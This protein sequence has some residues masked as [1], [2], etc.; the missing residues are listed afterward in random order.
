MNF[1]V[2]KVK[3]ERLEL[4]EIIAELI[5]ELK[6]DENFAALFVRLLIYKKLDKYNF[7]DKHYNKIYFCGECCKFTGNHIS[8]NTECPCM[9]CG[10]CCKCYCDRE[11][12]DGCDCSLYHRDNRCQTCFCSKTLL[13]RKYSLDIGVDNLPL[14]KKVMLFI[15]K[16]QDIF[17]C[18]YKMN[19]FVEEVVEGVMELS[20][21]TRKSHLAMCMNCNA[22]FED[23]WDW[24]YDHFCQDCVK[25]YYFP[26]T[27]DDEY[28]NA[29]T[30]RCQCTLKR[31]VSKYINKHKIST[32][33][34]PLILVDVPCIDIYGIVWDG[35]FK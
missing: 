15:D 35:F 30:C 23:E 25:K 32:D 26:K 31:I 9:K 29:F 8:G 24:G 20:A 6:K 28:S 22:F 17:I 3:Y 7:I 4:W 27:N 18:N 33:K 12:V 1:E 10:T 2:E 5:K 14:K 19:Y 21:F 34:I 11:N 16:L 13:H